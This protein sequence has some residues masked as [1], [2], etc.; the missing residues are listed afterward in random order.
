MF[1]FV[2]GFLSELSREVGDWLDRILPAP[3]ARRA[4]RRWRRSRPFWAATWVIAGGVEMV[5]IPLAPLPLMIKV[6]IGAVSAVGISVVLVAGGLFFLFKPDQRMFVSIVTAVASLTSLA[7]TNLGGFGMGMA[8]GLVGSSMAFGWMP[9]PAPAPRE[10]AASPDAGEPDGAGRADGDKDLAAS[11]DRDPPRVPSTTAGPV[12]AAPPLAAEGGGGLPKAGEDRARHVRRRGRARGAVLFALSTVLAA[13]ALPAGTGSAAAAPGAGVSPLPWP[14]FTWPWDLGPTGSPGPSPTPSPGD[15]PS[16]TSQPSPGPSSSPSRDGEDE[17]DDQGKDE[18]KKDQDKDDPRKDAAQ[19]T[20]PC[21]TGIDTGGLPNPDQDAPGSGEEAE[22]GA[23]P[24]DPDD[25]TA[26][27]PPIVI[28]DQ[29]GRPRST[30]PVNTLYPEVGADSLTA[31]GAVIHGATY[32]RTADGGRMK[33]L[34]VHADRLVADD[35]TFRLETAGQ[36]QTIDVDLDIP[37]VD[38]YV[39]QLTGSITIPVIDVAT[40]RICI[41]ADIVPANLPIAVHLPELSVT[42]VE[43]GQV[44]VDAETVNFSGLK[45]RTLSR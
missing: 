7:T 34:W 11:P 28:G 22:S 26:L 17:K 21:L 33:V 41:G 40:P 13:T 15:A 12:P 37:Q 8:A 35:Y 36:V 5:A 45:A 38:I 14:T 4:F 3:R 20:L 16:A 32:L 9:H 23:M 6:G 27:R 25:L 18:D 19:V 44:L 31:H 42:A 2:L 10:E 39:T 30:Y 43:A 1:S 29:P 24:G